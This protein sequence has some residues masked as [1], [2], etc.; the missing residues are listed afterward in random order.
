MGDNVIHYLGHVRMMAAAQPFISGAISKS[1]N[2]PEEATVEEI[3][4]L[5]IDAWRMGLKSIAIYR[6]NCKVAQP[7]ATT[8]KEVVV[9]PLA[10]EAGVRM[11]I[12]QAGIRGEGGRAD[13]ADRRARRGAAALPC[14]RAGDDDS[15]AAAPPAPVQHFRLP[16][17]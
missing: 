3:E 4:Q 12:E 15:H 9:V 13:G 17:G 8:K 10:D 2:M 11:E 14:D 5:H 1:V 16:G 7:L 6:D